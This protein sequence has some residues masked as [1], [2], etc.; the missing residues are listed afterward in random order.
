MNLACN[1]G[2][3]NMWIATTNGID[4]SIPIQR[5]S[6]FFPGEAKRSYQV[7]ISFNGPCLSV[8]SLGRFRRD[9]L[10]VLVCTLEIFF[11]T[12]PLLC[13]FLYFSMLMGYCVC[14]LLHLVWCVYVFVI[15]SIVTLS[16][17]SMFYCIL[18]VPERNRPGC[19]VVWSVIAHWRR[20]EQCATGEW[21]RFSGNALS[22]PCLLPISPWVFF[23]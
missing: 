6:H 7:L 5:W 4:E 10:P 22:L 8:S 20:R 1:Y 3:T 15:F 17:L 14:L 12:S 2:A 9:V 11:S 23:C 19:P 18:Q 21:N 16:S 13:V